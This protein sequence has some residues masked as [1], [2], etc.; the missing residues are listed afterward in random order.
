MV[1]N[2]K[3]IK[4]AEAILPVVVVRLNPTDIYGQEQ[5]AVFEYELP[6]N[7]RQTQ[8]LTDQFAALQIENGITIGFLFN[9]DKDCRKW[10]YAL[11]GVHS[12]L[13]VS[14]ERLESIKN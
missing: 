5:P 14:A 2:L 4:V 3:L 13:E 12:E 7:F 9:S 10:S 6:T 1:G 11:A 8:I